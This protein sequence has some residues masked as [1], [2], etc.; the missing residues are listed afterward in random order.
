MKIDL[1]SVIAPVPYLRAE[2]VGID[3]PVPLLDGSQIPY[4]NLDNAASTPIFKRVKERI[5]EAF[6]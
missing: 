2:I 3:K 1:A 6:E 4:V 5:P